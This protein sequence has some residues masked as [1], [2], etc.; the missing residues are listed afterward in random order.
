MADRLRRT[1]MLA[2]LSGL[3]LLACT[4]Q[5]KLQET[6]LTELLGWMPG[7][8]DGRAPTTVQS[9][10]IMPHGPITMV[11]AKVYAPRLGHHVFY[12]QEMAADD[13]LRVLS[14]RMFS[15]KV[16]E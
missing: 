4:S 3:S 13:P 6:Q 1:G 2:L 8:Y 14:Q 9:G 10:V 15:F 7:T 11:V 12:A 5:E 16:Y